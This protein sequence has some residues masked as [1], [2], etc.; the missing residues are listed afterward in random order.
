MFRRMG[1]T[2]IV[3]R[4]VVGVR[5]THKI[6]VYVTG[7]FCGFEV[8]WVV[9]CKAW[10]SNVTKEKVLALLSIVK[11]V[12]AD[13]GVLLSEVGFQSGAILMARMTNIVLTSIGDLSD[14]INA[15][16]VEAVISKLSWRLTRITER[17]RALDKDAEDYAWTP[18]LERQHKLFVLDLAFSDALKGN[19]PTVYAVGKNEERLKA[20]DF[21]DLVTKADALI[22]ECE[23]HCE[24][25]ETEAQS[26][27]HPAKE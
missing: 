6:D 16:V 14:Q 20:N 11:D 9:E 25:V 7:T 17:L 13:K 5:G 10:R 18:Q 12:G 21:D 27:S 2:A 4:E 3:E 15:G 24:R 22:S 23:E 19:F 26:R 8:K 1:L